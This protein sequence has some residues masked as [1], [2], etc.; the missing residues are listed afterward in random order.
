VVALVLNPV[1]VEDPDALVDL[2]RRTGADRGW[3]DPLVLTTTEEDPGTSMAR[4]ALDRGAD[5]VLAAGGDGT[6]RAVAQSLAGT[7]VP[8]GIVPA[9]TGNLL[10][11]NLELPLDRDEAVAVALGPGRRTLDLGR[12]DGADGGQVFAV[13]A[14]AGFDAEVMR[15]A[16]EKL[17]HAVGWPAYLVGAARAMRRGRLR[18]EILLDAGPA[19]HVRVHTV[20]VGNLG[21]LQ[22]G[23][24]LMPDARPDD[25]LLDVCVVSPRTTWDWLGVAA[26]TLVRASRPHRRIQV[27]QA[28][29]VT[30]RYRSR[31]PRQLDGDLIADGSELTARVDAA[32]LV[33]C[34]RPAGEGTLERQEET[35]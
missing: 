15:S 32:A 2:V 12:V 25:G 6:V 21:R 14:G 28:S 30:V 13:M 34:V 11:R 22:G 18:A 26:R 5:V 7:G 20:V 35:G 8:L 1:K 27:H 3:A 23:V 24:E 9:G 19:R 10:A 17:K 31:Q 29:H 4:E 16:P 33:V